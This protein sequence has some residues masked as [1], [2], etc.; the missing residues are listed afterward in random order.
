MTREQF[1]KKENDIL[2]KEI[3]LCR[4]SKQVLENE[5][6]E[7]VQ[8]IAQERANPGNSVLGAQA[9]ETYERSLRI[10]KL[11]SKLAKMKSSLAEEV[12]RLSKEFEELDGVYSRQF[13][14]TEGKIQKVEGW[15]RMKDRDLKKVKA[16]SQMVLNQ[17]NNLESYL[18]EVFY[19]HPD[20]DYKDERNVNKVLRFL[21]AK[22]NSRKIPMNYKSFLNDSRSE[23]ES[24]L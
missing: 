20:L 22:I 15:L 10:I 24:S 19:E 7:L 16:C 1:I 6:A 5:C 9:S 8:L 4:E 12:A 2:E 18:L 13:Q 21:F 11:E 17:R 3:Q 23:I 14:E